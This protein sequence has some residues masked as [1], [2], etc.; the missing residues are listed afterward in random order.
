MNLKIIIIKKF[1]NIIL[2][3]GELKKG[4]NP[5]SLKNIDFDRKYIAAPLQAGFITALVALAVSIHLK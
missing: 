1:L 2:Q 4:I 3:V 5:P